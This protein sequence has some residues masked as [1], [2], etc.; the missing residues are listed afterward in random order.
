MRQTPGER[1]RCC[2]A[3]RK[4]GQSRIP[5][6]QRVRSRTGPMP[7]RWRKVWR[8]MNGRVAS[9]RDVEAFVFYTQTSGNC[10]FKVPLSLRGEGW[11]EG[12]PVEFWHWVLDPS[13]TSPHHA[14]LPEGDGGRPR[15][16]SASFRKR[17]IREC[18]FT[19]DF[20]INLPQ[21]IGLYG[22]SERYN[23]HLSAGLRLVSLPIRV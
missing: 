8:S 11:G 22:P 10:R 7:G 1:R 13:K 23:I 6:C 18:P 19:P 20:P 2:A 17:T 12:N 15:T 14:P 4:P 16:P 3:A 5:C 9:L 21:T